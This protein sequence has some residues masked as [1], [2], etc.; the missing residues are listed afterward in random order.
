MNY[1]HF[2]ELLGR[3]SDNE[4]LTAALKQQG[5][6]EIPSIPPDQMS[7]S[8]QLNAC[9]LGFS[10][11]HLWLGR[12]DVDGDISAFTGMSLALRNLKWGTYTGPLPFAIDSNSTQAQLRSRFGEPSDSDEDLCWDEWTL[13]GLELRIAYTDDFDAIEAVSVNLPRI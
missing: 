7:V 4:S 5:V 2:L 12:T 13:D 9:V 11:P 1:L 8:V 3:T 10:D 6:T